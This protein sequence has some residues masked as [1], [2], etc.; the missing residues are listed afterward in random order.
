MIVI[1]L[2]C[3]AGMSTSLLVYKMQESAKERNLDVAIKAYP[4]TSIITELPTADVVLLGT[5]VVYKEAD[6][7]KLAKPLGIPVGVISLKDYGML[8]GKGVLDE[9]LELVHKE[10]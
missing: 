8:N 7:L 9:A 2:F 10:V 3:N 6:T 1:K 5:Q 4:V